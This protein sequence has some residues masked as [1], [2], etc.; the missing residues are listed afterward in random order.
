MGSLLAYA[1]ALPPFITLMEVLQ[2]P[3][4][5]L[6][7]H[8]ARC[9]VRSV[10]SSRLFEAFHAR[11]NDLKTGAGQPYIIDGPSTSRRRLLHVCLGYLMATR[12]DAT[13]DLCW[14]H[15]E[16]AGGMTEKA[17]ALSHLVDLPQNVP[18][19]Q[20]ALQRFYQDAKGDAN[21]VDKW[22]AMQSRADA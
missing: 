13:T 8:H 9:R 1:L 15:F 6:R 17:A 18:E 5:P 10:L 21:V 14:R 16:S 4:D 7:L 22:F 2:P 12:N 11:Y 19:R 3:I 20:E